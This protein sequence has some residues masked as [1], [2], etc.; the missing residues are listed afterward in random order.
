M[1]LYRG[2]IITRLRT[3]IMVRFG[4]R[5]SEVFICRVRVGENVIRKVRNIHRPMREGMT[6]MLFGRLN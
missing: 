4:H 2:A 3:N 6:A 1:K 5:S